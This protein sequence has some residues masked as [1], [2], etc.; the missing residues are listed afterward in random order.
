MTAASLLQRAGRGDL[1]V[2]VG[3]AD[4]WAKATRRP[5]DAP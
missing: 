3:G 4:D 5:L 1:T 2:L